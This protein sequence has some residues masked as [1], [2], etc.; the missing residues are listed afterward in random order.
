MAEPA[1][2]LPDITDEE[3]GWLTDGEK[4]SGA[5]TS[6]YRAEEQRNVSDQSGEKAQCNGNEEEDHESSCE[7]VEHC[8]SKKKKFLV[9]CESLEPTIEKPR[10]RDFQVH[11]DYLP[12][13][14]NGPQ[15]RIRGRG[16]HGKWMYSVHCTRT[17]C[18]RRWQARWWR[19]AP[20]SR[21]RYTTSC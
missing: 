10:F 18:A 20:M 14:P 4:D 2:P 12:C 9:E 8:I 7:K 3:E 6:D 5:V 16:R 21:G 15:A 11:H 17:Q 19:L 13:F 1:K